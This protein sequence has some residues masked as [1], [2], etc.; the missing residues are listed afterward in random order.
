[1]SPRTGRPKV[2]NPKVERI[3]TRITPEEKETVM[4]FCKEHNVSILD[5]IRKGMDAIKKK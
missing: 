1:M 2:D 4:S 5:L 3:V